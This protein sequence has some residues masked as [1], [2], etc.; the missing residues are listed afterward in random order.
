MLYISVRYGPFHGAAVCLCGQQ[1]SSE[2]SPI[3]SL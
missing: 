1:H 2:G 3:V